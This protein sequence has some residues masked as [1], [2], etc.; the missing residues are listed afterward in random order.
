MI[1]PHSRPTIS[2]EDMN[3]VVANLR[4]GLLACGEEVAR[5][6]QDLSS[7]I[8]VQGGVATNSGTSALHL[9][10]EALDVGP[11]DEVVVPSYVCASVLHA[12]K[13]TGASPVLADIGLGNYNIAPKSVA[14]RITKDTKG[15][16][17]PHLFGIAADIGELLQLNVPIIEDCAQSIGAEYKGRKLGSYGILST[18]SFKATK[19]VTTGHG[20]MVVT[21]S[22]EMLEKL[23]D[24]AK[25]DELDKYH[26]SHNYLLTDF[27]AALG[28]SQ[29]KR[30]G[31]FIERR[32]GIAEIYDDVFR[33]IGQ[34]RREVGDGIMFRYVVDVDN[35]DRY[36]EAMKKGG[37][38]CARPV[39]KPLHEYTVADDEFP[40]TER[41]MNRT[42]SIPIYPSLSDKEIEY[43]C[44]S[45][46]RVWS[47]QRKR[48]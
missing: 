47:E 5:F 21:N 17:V 35:A 38:Y 44:R 18:F 9:A 41:A 1:I 43:V 13:C 22:R 30:L 29:L 27:Q 34:N 14:G 36:I 26:A 19:L 8:G 40:N 32:L 7:Y 31:P 4:S 23:R 20:G 3:C 28:R 15:M 16:I 37:I 24:L 46:E 2:E 10:L 25:Y 42:V 39:F 11:G 12:V 33:N 48:R 6:E 45:V